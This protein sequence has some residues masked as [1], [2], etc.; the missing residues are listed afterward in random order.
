[1]R[2]NGGLVGKALAY[3]AKEWAVISAV[4]GLVSCRVSALGLWVSDG[5]LT[6]A[7]V[8]HTFTWHDMCL[9][10]AAGCG[11]LQVLVQK[12]NVFSREADETTAS[13]LSEEVSK[14][15]LAATLRSSSAPAVP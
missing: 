7:T 15:S 14:D 13:S 2:F 3:H 11:S 9:Q 8:L 12:L 10:Y 4:H 1:M 5:H 6:Y